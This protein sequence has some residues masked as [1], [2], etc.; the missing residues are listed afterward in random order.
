MEKEILIEKRWFGALEI[1]KVLF[2]D[3]GY[4]TDYLN[5]IEEFIKTSFD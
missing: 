5:Q 4:F 1:A 2:E 3:N